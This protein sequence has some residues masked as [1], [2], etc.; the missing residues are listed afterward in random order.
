MTGCWLVARIAAGDGSKNESKSESEM[1][2]RVGIGYDLHRLVS[3]RPFIMGG[4]S[5][6]SDRGPEGHSDGDALCHAVAD[7]LLG[8]ASLGD[9]GV[10]FPPDDPKLKNAHSLSLLVRV[11]LAVRE[12]GYSISNIDS[13]VICEKPK[14]SLHYDSM[15][16][17]LAEALGLAPEQVSIKSK[18]NEQ[19]G[20]I[21][22]GEAV[23]AWAVVLLD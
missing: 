20:E 11:A 19:L 14:L 4:V 10:W 12:K 7:A 16:E 13:T 2:A 8:A 15:R 9:I 18:T 6:D 22:R 1:R 17:R 5:I 21:G 3:G 23:A